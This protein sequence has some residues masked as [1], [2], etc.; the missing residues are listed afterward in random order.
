MRRDRR[1]SK[2]GAINRRALFRYGAAGGVVVAVEQAI[3]R[4]DVVLQENRDPVERSAHPSG[5]SLGVQVFGDLQRVRVDLENRAQR[6]T[7]PV[8]RLDAGGVLFHE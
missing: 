4:P 8:Q 7:A 2:S 1:G 6:R 3:G 5:L